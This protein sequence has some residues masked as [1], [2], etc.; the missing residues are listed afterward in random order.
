LIRIQQK[1]SIKKLLQYVFLLQYY[2]DKAFNIVEKY[3]SLLIV[4]FS[5][6]IFSALYQNIKRTIQ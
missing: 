2:L 4:I 1:K 6:I 5:H 3:N